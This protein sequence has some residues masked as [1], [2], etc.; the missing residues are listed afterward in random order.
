MMELHK[1][2]LAIKKP[3]HLRG[4][5]LILFNRQ[6]D[7]KSRAVVGCRRNGQVSFVAQDNMFGN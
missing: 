1:I 4:P 2:F 5:F 3:S 6:I 7:G